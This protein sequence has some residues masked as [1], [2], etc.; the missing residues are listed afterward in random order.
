MRRHAL[1]AAIGGLALFARPP[2]LLAQ[3][4]TRQVA[5]LRGTAMRL[6]K[7]EFSDARLRSLRAPTG[8]RVGVFASKLGAPRMLAVGDDGTVYVT[9]PDSNDVIALRDA[10]GDG[11][12]E[13]MRKVAGQLEHV[14]GIA[15]RDN[16]LFL[17][18]VKEVYRLPLSAAGMGHPVKILEGLPD[19]SQH[20][21]RTIGFGTDG[22]L[23]VSIGS[24]CNVC[25]EMNREAAAIL[26]ARADGSER[27]VFASGLRN[28]IGFA[29]HPE[30]GEMWGL[31]IGADWRGD[32]LPP[33]E[34]NRIQGA[35]HYG[36][37][38]CIGDRRPDS[39]FIGEPTGSSKAAF[40]RGTAAP[41]LTLAAHSSP[42]GI[43]FY[44]GTQFPEAYRGDAFVA[45]RGSWNRQ[46]ASGYKVMRIRF[47]S[48]KPVAAED[49]V[50]GFLLPGGQSYFARIA[51]IAVARDGALLVS[52]DANGVIYRVTYEGK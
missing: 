26:R 22:M 19:G 52:D 28:T 1:V 32:N 12:A 2:L 37:P 45:A 13:V 9:R 29:W 49:F 10:D 4:E 34:L 41:A 46:V 27:G 51:G 44:T 35:T 38:F 33:E 7:A 6:A 40:C 14:H 20:P 43:A 47:D 3:Q 17:A 18:T 23:Y 42:I 25:I 24:T 5:Q 30:T 50:T 8:F 11:N 21:K 39:L 15:L 48:G 36:W 31:D 16:A